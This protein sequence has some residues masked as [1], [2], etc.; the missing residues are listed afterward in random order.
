MNP[1]QKLAALVNEARG[2]AEKA[3][4]E[5]RGLTADEHRRLDGK[6]A[7]INTLQAQVAAGEKSA[8]TLAALDGLAAG[9]DRTDYSG[10]GGDGGAFGLGGD[11]KS[12]LAFTKGMA[13]K[14]IN[15]VM[16]EGGS[17]AIASGG[18]AVVDQE[19]RPDPIAMGQP[20][21]NLLSV[22]P[23]TQHDHPQFSYLRQSVR[24]N[25]AAIVADGAPKPT[26]VYTVAKIDDQLD[27]IAHLSEGIPR[28][29]L[30][31]NAKLQEWLTNELSYGL[32]LAVEAMAL[33]TITGTS[34]IQTNAF[35]TSALVT[36]RKSLTKLETQ[37]YTPGSF[38]VHPLDFEAIELLISSTNA[39]EH[40]GLPYD[41]VARRLYGVPVVVTN[42]ATQGTSHTLAADAAGLDTDR[43]G[44]LIQWSETSNS[45]DWS[46]NLIRA[47]VEGR[48]AT[49]VFRPL[50]VVKSTL[51]G[52]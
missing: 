31:D 17:K 33:A 30:S 37:G 39:V 51:T 12:R 24:T 36:L 10:R 7:E 44:I 50:G 14:A 45:D 3:Q 5:A 11:A 40:G 13:T 23:V 25:N 9:A 1:K 47:R 29:W 27:V 32:L 26:S 20:A 6:M 2:I 16:G 52:S 34:G 49:S 42:A 22:L 35:A 8:A 18:A 38:V 48:F 28:Y 4:H 21:L 19:F 41:P 46:K 43:Q 15:K